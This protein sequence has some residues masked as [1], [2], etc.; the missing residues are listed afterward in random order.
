M[1]TISIR[2]NVH[3]KELIQRYAD[4]FGVSMSDFVRQAVLDR[5]EDLA[6]LADLEIYERDFDFDRETLFSHDEILEK[7][8]QS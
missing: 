5:I 2:T 6:D 4:F 8:S 3:E 1:S 7:L